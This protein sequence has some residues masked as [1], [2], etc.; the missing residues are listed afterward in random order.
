M[1]IIAMM[2]ARYWKPLALVA[3]A[4]AAIGYRAILIHQRD[5]ARREAAADAA[6][7]SRL[8][9]DNDSLAREIR[10]QNDEVEAMRKAGDQ[11]AQALG[12][13][14]QAAARAAQHE[15]VAAD[16]AARALAQSH[17]A[18]GCDEAMRWGREKAKE[19]GQW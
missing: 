12:A 7:I 10:N 4:A 15:A 6:A 17:I 13:R 5:T 8:R 11:Q 9:A 3:L 14:A 2:L 19:L 1:P 16:A 18:D